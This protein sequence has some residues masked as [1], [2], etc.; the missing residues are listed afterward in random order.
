[1]KVV[2]MGAGAMG[3]WVGALLAQGGQDVTLVG[4]KDHVAVVSASG[5]LVS[6]KTE[7]RVR[8]RAVE[9]AADADV[10]D[11]LVLTVKAYDTRRALADARA[12]LGQRT[13]VLTLQNGLG[14][15]EQ[16]S[17][18]VDERRVF[19]AVTTH[20]VTFVEPGHVRHAGV[21]YFRV[22]SPANEHAA[23]REIADAFL[24]SGLDVE[25]TDRILGEIW[26]KVVVNASINPLTAITG[27][28]N[29]A[30]LE[31]APL[32]ELM[33]RVV[34]EAVDVARAEGAPLPEDDL[35]LRARRVAELTAENKSSML[36]DVERGRRT[37]VDAICGEIV[38]RGL[39]RG[40]DTPVNMT[41]SALVKGI[42][43]STRH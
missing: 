41:L 3:S 4:R 21:G 14:N 16:V 26:A 29:G 38:A 11:L 9:R 31:F 13:R 28:R 30:L 17:E 22:G 19:A 2:V 18:V 27:L 5:L 42:E 10:P 15:V 39:A 40:V 35:L 23:A 8:L 33:Q 24:A 37:E 43:E 20:G 25:A 1:M 7:L 6:G 32:R 36:Q 34:E 12:L